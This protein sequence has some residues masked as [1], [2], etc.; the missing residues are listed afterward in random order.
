MFQKI[1]ETVFGIW[2]DCFVAGQYSGIWQDRCVARPGIWQDCF[3]AR[4]QFLACGRIDL[5]LV[6]VS[7]IWQ[8]C[9]V[10]RRQ[11]L[12]SGRI[13]LLLDLLLVSFW[14]LAGSICCSSVYLASGMIALLLVVSFWHL[15][16]LICCSS[17]SGIWHD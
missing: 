6:R 2:Q 11:F 17:V 3:V 14:H 1:N 9:V 13:D 5:L 15:A 12:A 10:A 4:R 8:D 7:G 16:G